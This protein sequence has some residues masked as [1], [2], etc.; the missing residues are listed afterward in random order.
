LA[1]FVGGQFLGVEWL[2][3]L[4]LDPQ[5]ILMMLALVI[6]AFVMVA[7]LMVAMGAML[8]DE[9]AGQQIALVFISLYMIP[10]FLAIPLMRA[11]NSALAVALSIFPLTAPVVLPL[12]TLFIQVPF[13]QF[14]AAVTIQSLLAL[15]ALWLV[16]RTL[17][18][19]M[20][21]Y[22]KRL[23]WREL[24]GMAVPQARA[25]PSRDDHAAGTQ[26]D[27]H[28]ARSANRRTTK[29]LLVLRHEL[30][31]ALTKPW[32]ALMCI[33]LPLL[34][35]LQLAALDAMGSGALFRAGSGAASE[36]DM[37]RLAPASEIQ[38]YVDQRGLIQS[39]P[40]DIPEGML[41]P[42]GDEASAHDALDA[43]EID[44][45]YVIPAG[46]VETG[47]LLAVRTEYS[48]LS[49]TTGSETID[50]VLLVNLLGGDV[51][52]A[53]LVWNPVELQA[54]AWTPAS[55]ITSAEESSSQTRTQESL[56]RL[57]PTLVMLLLYGVIVLASSLLLGS[58]SE[59]KKGRVMEVLLLSVSPL[60]MLSG[61][62]VALGLAGLFQA[63]AW[64]IMGYLF[65]LLAGRPLSMPA[66]LDLST[67]VLVWGAVFFL[68]GYALYASLTA[69]AGALVPDLKQAR[70]VS[71]MIYAPA[72]IGFYI[73]L[74]TVESPHGWLSTAASLFPLTAPFT[75]MS[76]LVAGGVPT[77]QLFLSA[78][79]LVVTNVFVVRAVARMFQA[80][81][82]LS[83]QPASP[84]H[85]LRELL[86][87]A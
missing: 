5:A 72:L 38:G 68:P 23:H 28:T 48:P 16:A 43:G 64:G 29:T 10:L 18:L 63:A 80:Q 70:P 55:E 51:E 57:I 31:T 13:W 73:G 40:G 56:A 8:T 66:G 74:M 32:F 6:P 17:R 61:K 21:R 15:G 24:L 22:G 78:G 34:I 71:L 47:E 69:G 81:N 83:G 49:P 37:A 52:L 75:M 76:R 58:I 26:A 14:A 30:V 65:Y 84:K 35:F 45:Y 42:F 85:Y 11:P 12:R 25:L 46:Y 7:A 54:T 2:Q 82:L 62:I 41:V 77:W 67:S 1:V 86:G 59:E 4:S 9:Q 27:E 20:L 3:G 79:L 44:A 19:G 53:A 33:G 87:K 60:Q 36:S 50:W 39:I